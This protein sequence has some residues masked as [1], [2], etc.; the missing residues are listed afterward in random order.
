MYVY[1]V[2]M[3]FVSVYLSICAH[4]NTNFIISYSLGLPWGGQSG[5]FLLAGISESNLNDGT[6][7][8]NL[9]VQ[10]WLLLSVPSSQMPQLSLI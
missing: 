3:F 4:T 9:I 10:G 2:C 8:G 6:G 5:S 7:L 1:I